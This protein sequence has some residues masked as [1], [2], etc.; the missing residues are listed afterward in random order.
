MEVAGLVSFVQPCANL[1]RGFLTEWRRKRTTMS[2]EP[3]KLE[4]HSE[5]TGTDPE[6]VD[7]LGPLIIRS[8]DL[9]QGRREIWIAHGKGMYRLRRTSSGRLYLSK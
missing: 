7:G 3:H 2:D 9:L 4:P 6:S 8:E 5:T 1:V